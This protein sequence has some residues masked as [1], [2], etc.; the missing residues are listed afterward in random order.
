MTR[1]TILFL[2]YLLFCSLTAYFGFRLLEAKAGEICLVNG[3]AGAV[4]SIV[5][6][7]AKLKVSFT[8]RFFTRLIIDLE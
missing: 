6:Q 1:D 5:G 7:L 4:G 2:R 8:I 3:A